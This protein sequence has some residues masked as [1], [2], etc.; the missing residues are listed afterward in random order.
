[1]TRVVFGASSS[2]FLLAATIRKHLKQYESEHPQVVEIISSL[3]YVDDFIA[4]ASEVTEANT[5][6]TTAKNIMSAAGMVLCKWMTN[7]PELKERWQESSMDCA[8][9]PETHGSVLKV[10]GLV[11]RP[12]TDDF[13]FDLRG[14]LVI[15]KDR[16]NT[17]RS[18]LRSS[19]RIFDPLGFLTPFT[20]R[21]KCLKAQVG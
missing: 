13:V 11:L 3:L 14:L 16:E 10:L 12:A 20:V 2:P 9:E 4:S 17:K 18:V 19:A 6:T 7:S 15:L 21:I 1:M 5:V 8:V